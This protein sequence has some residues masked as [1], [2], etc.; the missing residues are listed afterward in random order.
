MKAKQSDVA[1]GCSMET[2]KNRLFASQTHVI[3]SPNLFFLEQKNFL[4]PHCESKHCILSGLC[5]QTRTPSMHP[6]QHP[7]PAELFF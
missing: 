1:P 5:V 2:S 4:L 7:K 6:T 3:L